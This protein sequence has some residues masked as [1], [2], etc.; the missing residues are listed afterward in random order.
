[1]K[2]QRTINKIQYNIQLLPGEM[3]EA[4]HEWQAKRDV[5]ELISFIERFSDEELES[6]FGCDYFEIREN[7]NE[8][9]E[10]MRE[11]IDKDDMRLSEAREQAVREVINV[12][13]AVS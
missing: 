12:K 9:A 7:K 8:I 13:T 4:F 5:E 1:M 10:T 6:N 3:T 11:H 2:I